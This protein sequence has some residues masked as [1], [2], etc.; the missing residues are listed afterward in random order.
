ML[1]PPLWGVSLP[2]SPAVW[3]KSP[4]VGCPNSSLPSFEEER[5]G[6]KKEMRSVRAERAQ[7]RRNLAWCVQGRRNDHTEPPPPHPMLRVS[8]E[9]LKVGVASRPCPSGCCCSAATRALAFAEGRPAAAWLSPTASIHAASW[10]HLVGL[11]RC[12]RVCS[13]A[14]HLQARRIR[15]CGGGRAESSGLDG[16]A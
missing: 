3:E 2:P 4:L 8:A 5:R 14:V 11:E 16:G 12:R 15:G 13:R 6:E 1:L 7:P 10:G 9:V